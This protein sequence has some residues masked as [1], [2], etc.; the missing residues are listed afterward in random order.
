MTAPLRF[1]VTG[2]HRSGTSFVASLLSAWNVAMGDRLLPADAGNPAGYFEDVRFLELNRRILSSCTEDLPGHRDWGWT[3]S[4]SF[5]GVV[6]P[7]FREEALALIAERDRSSRRWGFKDPRT[8]MLLDFWDEQLGGDAR[9]VLV[10][11]RPWEVMDSMLRSGAPV[12]LTHPDYAARIWAEYNRRLIDFH[13]RHRDRTLLVSVNRLL[14][15]P[16]SFANAIRERL[17]LEASPQAIADLRSRELFV[18]PPDDDPL[19][20]LWSFTHR[21]A[22]ELLGALDDAADLGDERRWERASRRPPVARTQNARLSIIIPCRDDGEYLVEAVASVE[23][24]A[25]AAELIVVDDGSTQPRTLE[26][27]AALRLAGHRVIEQQNGGISAA[28]NTGIAA[29]TGEYFLPLDADN[30]IL[31]GWVENAIASLDATPSAG[32]AYGDRRDF[33]ARNEDV[34]VPEFDLPRMLWSNY[35]DACAVVRRSVWAQSGGYDTSFRDCEDWDFWLTAARDRWSFLHVPAPAFEYRIRPGSMQHRFIRGDAYLPTLHRLYTKHRELIDAEALRVLEAAQTERRQLFFDVQRLREVQHGLQANIDKV[36]ADAREQ[37][38]ALRGIVRARDEELA[39]VKFVLRAR[40][41]ELSSLDEVR[42]LRESRDALEANMKRLDA[43][44]RE[45]I[46]ALQAIVA[47]RD[48]ELA[49]VKFVLQARDEELAALHDTQQ[50]PVMPERSLSDAACVFTIIARNYLAHARVLARSLAQHNPGAIL[51]VVLLDDVRNEVEAEAGI[52][53]IRP[54]ELPFESASEFHVMA[55][56]YDVT[57]LATAI[58]PWVFEHLFARGAAVVIYLDPDIEVFDSLGTIEMLAGE[59][60]MVITPHVTEPLPRDGQRPDDRDLLLAGIYNLGFLALGRAMATTFLPWWQERLRRDCVN[61]PAAG[62]FVDQRWIDFAPAMFDPCILRDPG[63][64]VAYWNLPH[65]TLTRDGERLLVNGQ[66]LRFFHYSGFSPRTPFLLSKHQ[67]ETQRIRLSETP[68]LA[69][70]CSGYAA[71]LQESGFSE[72][73]TAP[74]AFTETASGVPLEPRTR[75]VLRRTYLDDEASGE[76][77]SFPDPF[78]AGGADDVVQRL[79]RPSPHSPHVAGW[80]GELWSE[81]AD[82]RIAFPRID[83]TDAGRFLEWV[84]TQGV[85]EHEIPRPLVPP[86]PVTV[87]EQ[88]RTA[89]PGVN[90][91]G[92]AFAESGTGQIVRAAVSALAAQGIPYAVVPFTRTISRQQSAF[93]DLGTAAPAFDTN[94]ICVNADQVPVFFEAMGAQ[95]MPGA[96]NIGLWAWELEELPAAVARSESYLDEVWGISAFT[97][98]ALS[99]ALTKPVRAFPLPVAVPEVRRRSRAELAM[100]AGFLFLFCFDYDSVFRR[101][102]PLGV[103]AAFRRAF[104]ARDDV[105]LYIKTTNAARHRAEDEELRAAVAGLPNVV[106]RD[107][108]VTSDDYFSMLDACDCYV[109]L[110]RSEG[111]GLTVAEAMALGKPVITTDYSATREFA[112]V[113]NSY[114]VAARI[115]PIGNGAAPYPPKSHWA[116]PDVAAAADQMR[117][118]FEGRDAAAAVGERARNDIAALHSPSARGP[119]LRDLLDA[120]RSEFR[121]APASTPLPVDATPGWASSAFEADVAHAES[122]LGSPTPDLP[123]RMRRLVAPWRRFI[124]RAIRVYWV[125]QLAVDRATLLAMRTLRR[126]TGNEIARLRAELKQLAADTRRRNELPS[127]E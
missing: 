110:H 105:A 11:R 121:T 104:G 112:N 102:N 39:S 75:R 74:Y 98:D 22:I 25:P 12:W 99:R 113:S 61:E 103:V 44:A 55:A 24:N 111:F 66:P 124:L 73:S 2:M 34:A 65:R 84:R 70:L 78:S 36:D 52:E 91:Y 68:L 93:R 59:H 76:R 15:D 18:S 51:K 33:G 62:L 67:H 56:I 42:H 95:L 46:A 122:L 54:A 16:S 14:D 5:D 120:G 108:Y 38:A 3:E 89:T 30:R 23:R 13:R 53:Y 94:L 6:P 17:D 31:P 90:V 47:A 63:Y 115:V 86:A 127:Q 48:E 21:D 32:I 107:G 77:P 106:I 4:G 101:K 125:Q 37:I 87:R 9:F 85:R 60:G 27:L 88:Q 69:E 100:P 1:I 96:R 72:C 109:S 10:Y 82:L 57:E 119:L 40:E 19:P 35:I 26:V 20:R 81:R 79:L 45:Q 49:S 123:S 58:K 126:E 114:P 97:A 92:Y 50:A 8:T 43:D 71:A 80:L 118:V 83:S 117:R 29:S 116:E 7:A 64:N 28:R 41:Q